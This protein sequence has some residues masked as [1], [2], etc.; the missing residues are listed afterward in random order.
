V[1][2]TD[3]LTT[4][5]ETG[6]I[7]R[8]LIQLLWNQGKTGRALDLWEW[9]RTAPLRTAKG[10]IN[11]A[12]PLNAEVL[13]DGPPLPAIPEVA[14]MFPHLRTKT[15]VSYALL[16]DGVRIW[17]FDDA[18]MEAVFQPVDPATLDLVARRF[19]RE[20]ADA[21]SDEQLLKQDAV[22]LYRWLLAPIIS[23]I[24]PGRKIIVEPDGPLNLIPF[25][26][27]VDPSSEFVGLHYPIVSSLGI[28]YTR[29]S[30]SAQRFSPEQR[31]LIVSSPA[32]DSQ[33]TP[34]L[35]PL[36]DAAIEANTIAAKFHE[37]R[38][39]SG[40]NATR[41]SIERGLRD[42]AIFHFAGHSLAKADR[43]YLVL[44]SSSNTKEKVADVSGGS[45]MD[46]SEFRKQFCQKCQLVVLSA[47]S[48]AAGGD[49]S[50]SDP[51]S[52]PRAILRSGVPSVVASLW[53]VDSRTT[54]EYMGAF[55]DSLLASNSLAIASQNASTVIRT[56]SDRHHP[57]YWAAFVAFETTELDQVAR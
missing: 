3:V 8:D 11:R 9:Y 31:I 55:Y 39:V 21:N 38:Q 53:G 26:A 14:S 29:D 7:Y 23:H 12:A 56:G 2:E 42:A 24:K 28:F 10:P 44:A 50:L 47:C 13:D 33:F 15:I 1:N 16:R 5:R 27:L 48:T 35:P 52:L 18:G 22:R 34:V 25:Q 49:G 57:Y 30:I 40:S 41:D 51:S 37:A 4:D 43:S 19:S 20:C 46:A 32:L 17:K 36:P 45:L 54:N 6:P